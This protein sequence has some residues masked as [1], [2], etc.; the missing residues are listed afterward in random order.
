MI[1][2]FI[3]II[4]LLGLVLPAQA[5][6]SPFQKII[7]ARKDIRADVLDKKQEV[8]EEIKGQIQ[9]ARQ[10][11]REE[12]KEKQ[13]GIKEETKQL[14][15]SAIEEFQK[16]REEAKNFVE[17]KR[18]EFRK[19]TEE[20]RAE[21]KKIIETKRQEL[22]DK[23]VKIK[24]EKKK[25]AVEKINEEIVRVN[26]SR[27]NHFAEVLNKI[28]KAL[29]NVGSRADKAEANG[30]DVSSVRSAINEAQ[31]VISESRTAVA[32]QL[33][34]VYTITVS[35]ES[36]LKQDVGKTRQELQTDLKAVNNTIKKAHDAVRKAAVA[37][38]QIPKVNELEVS[39]TPSTAAEST[40]I[41]PAATSSE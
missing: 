22:K 24:D 30:R 20:K 10:N 2:T 16:K 31:A 37:L 41:T 21:A 3:Y 34:K 15:R 28:E 8:R 38:A 14:R 11:V 26:E 36:A 27:M 6:V 40:T 1:K 19:A 18:E 23:L 35:S 39:E 5:Q 4:L 9:D 25:I 33:G 12:I 29:A 7:D 13:Q 32:N 17:Q